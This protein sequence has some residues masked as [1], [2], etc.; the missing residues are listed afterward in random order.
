MSSTLPAYQNLR[1]EH[2]GAV[3]VLMVH[4]PEV[5]NALNRATIEELGA[6]LTAFETDDAQGALVLSGAGEK[7]FAAGADIN[8][9]AALDAQGAEEASR[10]GRARRCKTYNM[11]PR[12]AKGVGRSRRGRE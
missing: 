11:R 9:L 1:L 2:R 7:S 3:T 8:E 12:G 6:F 4:R 10:F 5:L